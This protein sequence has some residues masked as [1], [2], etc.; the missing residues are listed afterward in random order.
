ML[1]FISN[2]WIWAIVLVLIVA[3]I[4]IAKTAH[5][6]VDNIVIRSIRTVYTPVQSGASFVRDKWH[7]VID[8]FQ[9][10]NSLNRQITA[11]EA[12]LNAARIENASLKEYYQETLRLQNL[13]NFKNENLGTHNMVA[14]RVIARSPNSWN[15]SII[16]S[17]GSMQSLAVD[18]PVISSLGLVGRISRVFDNTAEVSLITDTEIAVGA[19][20]AI[21]RE[22]NGIVEGIGES[23]KLRMVNIPYYAKITENEQVLT[24]GLSRIYPKGIQIG[25]IQTII[26][27]PNGLLLKTYLTPAVDFNKLEEV[28]VIT[29]YK[30]Q[31]E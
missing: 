13:L 11:L 10:K 2:K 20:F 28:L 5:Q 27:E 30:P 14:A 21:D 19:I 26:H 24:S 22:T 25:T 23:D 18:M 4:S 9:S 8:F 6:P 1:R 7:G 3:S 16:I 12:E 15:D 31:F 17:K 29:D